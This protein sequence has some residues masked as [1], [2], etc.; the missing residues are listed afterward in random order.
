MEMN[1]VGKEKWHKRK[2]TTKGTEMFKQRMSRY[3][4]PAHGTHGAEKLTLF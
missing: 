2:K 3:K 4:V 1:Q